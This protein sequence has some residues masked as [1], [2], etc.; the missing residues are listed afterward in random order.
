MRPHLTV[1]SFRVSGPILAVALLSS[2]ELAHAAD[3]V[4]DLD[5]FLQT[6]PNVRDKDQITAY[7][8]N[9]AQRVKAIQRPSELRRAVL[10]RR[11]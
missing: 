4:D 8:K 2:L 7:Q 9:L 11:P 6:R 5:H 1:R 3:P 10:L